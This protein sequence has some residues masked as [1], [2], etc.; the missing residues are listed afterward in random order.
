MTN[1]GSTLDLSIPAMH[2]AGLSGN[3]RGAREEPA[4]GSTPAKELSAYQSGGGGGI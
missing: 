3:A 1:L 4:A 2:M